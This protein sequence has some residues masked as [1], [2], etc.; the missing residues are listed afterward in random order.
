MRGLSIEN[1]VAGYGTKIIVGGLSLEVGP[2]ETLVV[3]G[4]SGCGKSTLLL[5]ILGIVA[6]KS[7]RIFLNGREITDLPIEERNIGY[8]PQDYGLFPHLRVI[9]NVAYGLRVRG[10]EREE[11]ERIAKEMLDLVELEGYERHRIQELSGG[12]R[13][14]VSLAR[15][16][17]ISPKLL[18]L[19]EPLS[20]IDQVT[21]VDVAWQLKDLFHKLEI[22]VILVTHNREDALFLAERLAVMIDGR[23]EQE[24]NVKEIVKSPKTP[25]VERLLM[26][27]DEG[28][29]QN[30]KG[31][32]GESR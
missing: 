16:L 14:R 26:P 22:P 12:Q 19:D 30:E 10:V 17:A 4:P 5:T 23:I 31:V 3:M 32:K 11:Q 20:N 21:K 6:P 2:R 29:R 7:G 28:T 18:L 13:Q 9:D 25:F 8:L 1:I 15:A 27:F 24:G